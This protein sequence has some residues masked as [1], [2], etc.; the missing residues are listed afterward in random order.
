MANLNSKKTNISKKVN[1]FLFSKNEVVYVKRGYFFN[2]LAPNGLAVKM[3]K[4]VSEWVNNLSIK[5]SERKSKIIET[6][7]HLQ[8]R[9]LYFVRTLANNGKFMKRIQKVDIIS[10]IIKQYDCSG[11]SDIKCPAITQ[12]GV[13]SIGFQIGYGKHVNMFVVVSSSIEN[14]KSLGEENSDIKKTE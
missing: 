14:A 4:K 8:S 11:I 12:Y 2:Y 10:E 6:E 13:Y 5:E 1:V 3:S 7:N 9:P